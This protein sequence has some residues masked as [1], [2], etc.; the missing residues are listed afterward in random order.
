MSDRL[1]LSRESTMDTVA[2]VA[3]PWMAEINVE[4]EE[5]AVR[6]KRRQKAQQEALK[7][8]VPGTDMTAEELAASFAEARAAF[9]ER[10]QARRAAA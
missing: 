3:R 10:E 5:R 9:Y 1:P 2:S 7:R 6:R 8:L 4:R